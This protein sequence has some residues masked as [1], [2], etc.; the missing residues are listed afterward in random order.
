MECV[1]DWGVLYVRTYIQTHASAHMHTYT[2][3][4]THTHARTHT[5]T[6]P[7]HVVC[8]HVHMY[9][10]SSENLFICGSLGYVHIPFVLVG[11][12]TFNMK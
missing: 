6:P 1:F 8:T 2:H 3:T 9:T 7:Y 5:N 12:I 11:V 4:C 10:Y